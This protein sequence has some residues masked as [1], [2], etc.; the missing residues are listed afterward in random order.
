MGLLIIRAIVSGLIGG[1]VALPFYLF[2]QDQLALGIGIAIT[3]V[4]LFFT[5]SSLMVDR[6]AAEGIDGVLRV[7][8]GTV[9]FL[10]I[11]VIARNLP[12]VSPLEM[13]NQEEPP[14]PLNRP[15]QKADPG[16]LWR[17]FRLGTSAGIILLAIPALVAV[18]DPF[19]R[20]LTPHGGGFVFAALLG[21]FVGG[22]VLGGG[23]GLLTVSG[24]HRRNVLA[25]L[26]TGTMFG[27]GVALCLA[28]YETP[29]DFWDPFY[30]WCPAALLAG[31]L[32][33]I[34]MLD[35]FRFAEIDATDS[36]DE[37]NR[38]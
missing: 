9:R 2:G 11:F 10:A 5:I 18:F 14:A 31:G 15:I 13:L 25:G 35:N 1:G 23:F 27:A 7:L 22:L 28:A 24:I 33:G 36:I 12:G 37:A 19:D 6:P 16:R 26:S 38:L 32:I 20:A 8:G 17:R 21:V 3:A 4:G 29:R 30:F 34:L